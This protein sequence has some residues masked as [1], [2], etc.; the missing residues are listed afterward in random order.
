MGA[1]ALPIHV[2]T[3]GDPLQVTWYV[4]FTPVAVQRQ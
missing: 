4:D 2:E 3:V 1:D